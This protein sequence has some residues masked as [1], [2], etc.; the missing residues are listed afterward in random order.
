MLAGAAG[1]VFVNP[2]N[3]WFYKTFIYHEVV[4]VDKLSHP[5]VSP[6]NDMNTA[7]RICPKSQINFSVF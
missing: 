6:L 3:L 1:S 5:T 4:F 7:Y 2:L